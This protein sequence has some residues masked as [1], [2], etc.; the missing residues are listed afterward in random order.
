MKNYHALR[1]T[2]IWFAMIAIAFLASPSLG[3]PGHHHDHDEPRE[4]GPNGGRMLEDVEPHLEFLVDADRHIVLTPL[5][6]EG[7]VTS[8]SGQTASLTGGNRSAPFSMQ[9]A[10]RGDQALVSDIALPEGNYFPVILRVTAAEGQPARIIRFNMDLSSCPSCEYPEYA[11]I[12][13]H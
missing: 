11:C 5:N 6:D 9:F 2:T 3:G 13:G 7:G 4:A 10:P 12:C 1:I 8:L